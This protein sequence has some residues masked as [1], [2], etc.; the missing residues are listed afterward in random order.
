MEKLISIIVPVY[1]MERYINKCVDS[2]LSQTYTNIEIIL[3]D[4]GSR[5]GS[6]DICKEYEMRDPRVRAVHKANGGLSSARNAGLDVMHGELVTFVDA[7][8]YLEKEAIATMYEALVKENADIAN[9]QANLINPDYTVRSIKGSGTRETSVTSS[10]DYIRGMCRKQKSESVCDK[11]FRASLFDEARFPSGRLNED[12]FFLSKL[13]CMTVAMT[14]VKH[15]VHITAPFAVIF[16]KA[17]CLQEAF[18]QLRPL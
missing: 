3:V 2:L 6:L 17:N 10:H 13:L 18:L 8:D 9:M 11:L 16:A 4:D 12:F 7:D 5:D 15:A 14:A 1:N